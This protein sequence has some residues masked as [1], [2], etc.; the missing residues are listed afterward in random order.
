TSDLD[1]MNVGRAEYALEGTDIYD[2][3][4]GIIYD[5]NR[6][7][8]VRIDRNGVEITVSCKAAVDSA[9]VLV[10][11]YDYKGFHAYDR[12]GNEY[13]ILKGSNNLISFW[14]PAGYEGNISVKYR[15]P[16]YWNAAL[17]FSAA[18]TAVIMYP[19]KKRTRKQESA[20]TAGDEEAVNS[21]KPAD[22]SE[23]AA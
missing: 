13:T 20:V 9:K 15:S 2:D 4:E 22:A 16:W 12:E 8:D 19:S 21:E 11:L 14:I 6:D 17:I 5:N 3:T 18:G 10:P 23:K 7:R 1:S